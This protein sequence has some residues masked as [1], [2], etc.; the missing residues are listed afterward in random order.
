MTSFPG[1]LKHRKE[2]KP[3]CKGQAGQGREGDEVGV[4]CSNASDLLPSNP[5]NQPKRS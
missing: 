1:L 3:P 4:F 5:T 2:F